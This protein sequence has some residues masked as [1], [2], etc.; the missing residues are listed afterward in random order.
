MEIFWGGGRRGGEKEKEG[1]G[2]GKVKEEVGGE[3]RSSV[4]HYLV[5]SI[6]GV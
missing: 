1:E 6:E 3:S 5:G 4:L 2:G